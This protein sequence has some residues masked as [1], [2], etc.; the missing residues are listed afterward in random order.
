MLFRN[1]LVSLAAFLGV[2]CGDLLAQEHLNA[3][4]ILARGIEN[5][6]RI[7]YKATF[8]K[9]E[10]KETATTI[11]YN[12]SNLDGT[13]YRRIETKYSND[14]SCQ[15][16]I[17]N[18][19]GCF[20]IIGDTAIKSNW[21]PAN[22]E[23]LDQDTQE[24]YSV[25]D[26]YHQDIPCYVITKNIKADEKKYYKVIS[27]IPPELIKNYSQYQK[28]ELFKNTFS[29]LKV[30]YIG[31][32]DYF[33]YEEM[34]YNIKGQ[35]TNSLNYGTVELNIA[36]NDKLFQISNK[37]NV[38]VANTANDFVA[39]YAYHSSKN[40]E[41]I[42]HAIKSSQASVTTDTAPGIGRRVIDKIDNN[43]EPITTVLSRIFFWLSV[44][45][46]T[47]VIIFKLKSHFSR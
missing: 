25:L 37:L 5:L 24:T 1:L 27:I 45:C 17:E 18:Q 30:Y 26:G 11:I 12:K 4:D 14:P 7:N 23:I 46:I 31:K 21:L 20:D 10:G 32:Q 39:D 40:Y 15:I 34:D 42:H 13:N 36:L 8:I 29:T 38:K 2:A 44:T 16:Y 41:E 47:I 22:T 9:N 6:K 19:D 33:I 35:K 43:L 3:K 28:K